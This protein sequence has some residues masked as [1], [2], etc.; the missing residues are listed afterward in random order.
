MIKRLLLVSCLAA[1]LGLTACS[2]PAQSD[3]SE[4]LAVVEI[5]DAT[6]RPTAIGRDITAATTG[7]FRSPARWPPVSRFT[8]WR[9]RTA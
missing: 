4:P 3:E 7:W 6:C 5:V 1:P 2:P 9:P 8:K